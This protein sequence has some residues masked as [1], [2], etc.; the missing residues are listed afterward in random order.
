MRPI[1]YIL[2]F[3][4]FWSCKDNLDKSTDLEML[5]E[6]K[7]DFMDAPFSAE[8]YSIQK[9]EEYVDLI[10]LKNDHP[11]FGKTID[12]ELNTYIIDSLTA[13][14]YPKGFKISNIRAKKKEKPLQPMQDIIKLTY[15]VTTREVTVKDSIIAII[16][17]AYLDIDGTT[18]ISR[19][20]HFIK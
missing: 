20:I 5:E 11:D 6:P 16:N 14:K 7:S 13:L 10:Q 17:S 4:M 9:L 19:S 1:I 18:Q 3:L 8:D 15:T 2:C 12:K